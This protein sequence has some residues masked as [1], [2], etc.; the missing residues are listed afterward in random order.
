VHGGRSE[1]YPAFSNAVSVKYNDTEGRHAV[2]GSDVPVGK[3][4][5][6]EQAYAS[7]LLREYSHSHCTNCFVRYTIGR[8]YC[9]STAFD[10]IN[11]L[12]NITYQFIDDY[13]NTTYTSVYI[14][15]I[16][17]NYNLPI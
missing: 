13:L 16:N 4:L 10:V 1:V 3:V 11:I 5:L 7:V 17:I 2:A 12:N 14:I 8:C 9:L 15:I 6:V